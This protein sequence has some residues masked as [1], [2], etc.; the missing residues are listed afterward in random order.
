MMNK[1]LISVLVG[2]MLVTAA[3][4][5]CVMRSSSLTKVA[6]KIEDLADVR[7]MLS[8]SFNNERKCSIS[9][10]VQYHS[11]WETIYADYTGDPA[12]GDQ[13]LCVNAV[14]IG[15]RQFL[16]TKEA[17]LL[18]SEQQMVCTDETPIVVRPVKVGE[19]IHASEVDPDPANP[20]AFAYKGTQC[21]WFVEA[22]TERGGLY[23]WH[24]VIC[25]TGRANADEWT[26]VDKF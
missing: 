18:H 5:E 17:K 1:K 12:I 8:P 25:K 21:K 6:G 2:M 26:V 23:E 10:R 16:A 19:K 11:K 22:N 9:A 24:G 20:L 14:E 13:E 4:A 7:P 15:V 3:N